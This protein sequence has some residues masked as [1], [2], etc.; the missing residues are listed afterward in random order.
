MEEQERQREANF[1][2]LK[3]KLKRAAAQAQRGEL[4]DG[5]KVFAELR[6]HSASRRKVRA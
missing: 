2:A 6:Q 1:I 5:E 3:S 4:I